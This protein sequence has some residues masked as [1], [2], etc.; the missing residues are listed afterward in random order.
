MFDLKW[1]ITMVCVVELLGY[2]Q[3]QGIRETEGRRGKR[4]R[5]TQNA[6]TLCV[7][8]GVSM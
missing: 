1:A 7:Q 5:R 2:I 8:T 4:S 3:Q 6:V